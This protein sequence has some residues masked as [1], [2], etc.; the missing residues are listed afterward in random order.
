MLHFFFFNFEKEKSEF[1]LSRAPLF[2]SLSLRKKVKS[3]LL[4]SLS[5]NTHRY[6]EQVGAH[7][8]F[9]IVEVGLK[10]KSGGRRG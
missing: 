2:N 7:F 1:F 8:D 3:K 5:P 9:L 10:K 4:P 6:G